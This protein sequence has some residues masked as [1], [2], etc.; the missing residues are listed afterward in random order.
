MMQEKGVR[1]MPKVMNPE[2]GEMEEFDYTPEGMAKAEVRAEQVGEEVIPSY[3][4]GGRVKRIMG[5]GKGG[6]VKK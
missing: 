4:A 3:D 1:K 2:T 5:Y 6:K